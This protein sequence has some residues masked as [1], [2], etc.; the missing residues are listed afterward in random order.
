MKKIL[1]LLLI[2]SV[3]FALCSCGRKYKPQK[4][5]DEEARVVMT[6]SL[7]GEEYEIKYELYRALFLANKSD[8]DG[9]DEG[10]WTGANSADYINRINEIITEE[11]AYI[12][13]ALHLAE[14]L[15]IDVYSSEADDYVD[16]CITVCVEGDGSGI[17]GTGSYGKYL[18]SLKAAGLNYSVSDLMFRYSYAL[19]EINEYYLG[20]ENAAVGNLGGALDTSDE[21]VRSF[22]Y[23]D[24]CTRVLRA[25]VSSSL[26]S[27]EWAESFRDNLEERADDKSRALYIINNTTV[28]YSELI[29]NNEITGVIIGKHAMDKAYYIDYT[30]AAFSIGEGEVS[31]VATVK[32]T[33]SGDVDG[34][35]VFVS[36]EKSDSHLEEYKSDIK[37]AYIENAI[38]KIL[39]D[40]S[41]SL[42]GSVTYEDGYE[43]IS[44]NSISM[45]P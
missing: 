28:P 33:G 36:L 8:V 22:Y 13:S 30:S 3:L 7:D 12:Y 38:G 24:E 41:D 42:V 2:L 14:K 6:L 35:Y 11:A 27:R 18:G 32:G 26:R 15:D 21:S 9:G 5:T 44:H 43:S 10:V 1:S 16:E 4:S 20:E 45:D 40:I 31:R 37:D 34:Y 19:A 29:L 23:S 17:I 39:S 25:F